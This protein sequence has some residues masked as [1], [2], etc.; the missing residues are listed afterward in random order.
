MYIELGGKKAWLII[1]RAKDENDDGYK[2]GIL[3]KCYLQAVS[4]YFWFSVPFH[5][6]QPCVAVVVEAM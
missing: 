6:C 3:G 5:W 2:N 1:T 4:W